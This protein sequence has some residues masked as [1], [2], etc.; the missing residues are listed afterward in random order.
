MRRLQRVARRV[1]LP[2]LLALAWLV[3]SGI[4]TAQ[5]VVNTLADGSGGPA[6]TLRDAIVAANQSA[7]WGGCDPGAEGSYDRIDLTGLS[8]TIELYATLPALGSGFGAIRI[9][10]P[11]AD[12]LA[13]SAAEANGGVFVNL[14]AFTGDTS[15][16]GV[17]IRD[18]ADSC[19][20][21][22][23]ILTLRDC[24]I[25]SCHGASGGAAVDGGIAGPLT[26]LDRC[27]IDANTGGS[28]I[29]VGGVANSGSL[30]LQNSTVTG[31]EGGIV[32]DAEGPG[33]PHY[34]YASTIADNGPINL[35]V[36]A[37][38]QVSIEHVVLKRSTGGGVNCVLGGIVVLPPDTQQISS[39]AVIADDASCGL[40]PLYD[41]EGVDPMIG[42]LADNGGPTFTRALLPGSPAIDFRFPLCSGFPRALE[43][44]QRGPDYPRSLPGTPGA[45][46]RCDA[47]AFE[48]PEPDRALAA[49]AALA[50]VALGSRLRAVRTRSSTKGEAQCRR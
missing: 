17:T 22:E 6:C 16:E 27:L 28:A 39:L 20:V 12:R 2:R 31:N 34:L 11:G 49:V 8:G 30:R 41:L 1:R 32:V 5:I 18:G 29:R 35:F 33:G 50:G 21:N 10:G 45:E 43:M 37:D 44:D 14:D 13:I 19:V 9:R 46:P 26:L 40:D 36:E 3:P 23:G 25:T 24:R 7:P 47:G 42:P 15:I 4:A 48:V 38:D